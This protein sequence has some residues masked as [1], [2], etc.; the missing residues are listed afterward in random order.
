MAEK[1]GG[2]NILGMIFDG[3]KSAVT[4]PSSVVDPQDG[5]FTWSALFNPAK[6]EQFATT[7]QL[8]QVGEQAKAMQAVAQAGKSLSDLFATAPTQ[9]ATWGLAQS[10][11]G[12]ANPRYAGGQKLAAPQEVEAGNPLVDAARRA[13]NQELMLG[14]KASATLPAEAGIT[15]EVARIM[16]NTD[17]VDVAKQGSQAGFTRGTQYQQAALTQANQANQ[18]ALARETAAINR[19]GEFGLAKQKAKMEQ[20]IKARGERQTQKPFTQASERILAFAQTPEGQEAFK[21]NPAMRAALGVAQAV[22]GGG[23]MIPE[24][25][26]EVLET[27]TSAAQ[28]GATAQGTPEQFGM[29]TATQTDLNKRIVDTQNLMQQSEVV[30]ATFKPEWATL[31]GRGKLLMKSASDVLGGNPQELAEFR[32]WVGGAADLYSRNKLELTGQASTAQES[33]EIQRIVPNPESLGPQQIGAA[34]QTFAAAKRRQFR[35][36]SKMQEEGRVALTEAE[37]DFLI[38]T[39]LMDMEEK[40]LVAKTAVNQFFGK[41]PFERRAAVK[42]MMQEEAGAQP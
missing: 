21:N 20:R 18:A 31:K 11:G 29:S 2:S 3:L 23:P 6:R 14:R 12:S 36:L 40:K 38:L 42:T 30:L 16:Q 39:T 4:D 24:V 32:A 35:F 15:P 33:A 5:M 9:E 27:L 17:I 19:T 8:M 26:G 28:K 7:R 37:N 1:K 22:T 34:L 13:R 10:M 41:L 25:G